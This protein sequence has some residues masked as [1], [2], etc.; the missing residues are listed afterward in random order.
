MIEKLRQQGFSY[1]ARDLGSNSAIYNHSGMFVASKVPLKEIGL[2]PIDQEDRTGWMSVMT[3][4]AL[5]TFKVQVPGAPDLRF[6]NVHLNYGGPDHQPTRNRQL[7]KYV[8]PLTHEG[9]TVVLGDIN[10][11]TS[12][13]TSHESGLIGL[14]NHM[15]GQVTCTDEPKHRRWGKERPCED[16]AEKIDALITDPGR[17]RVFEQQP[18]P[19]IVANEYASDHFAVVANLEILPD[20]PLD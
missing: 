14:V 4:K 16:C 2:V 7:Q 9:P 12:T 15:E 18:L 11:D 8:V 1:F 6:V 19:L 20:H 13:V 17:V 3:N 5:L 10:F